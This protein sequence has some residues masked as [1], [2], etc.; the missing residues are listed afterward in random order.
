[1]SEARYSFSVERLKL[2]M[3]DRN[4]PEFAALVGIK[5]GMVSKYLEGESQPSVQSLIKIAAR[6]GT[7][8]DWLVGLSDDPSLRIGDTSDDE[9]LLIMAYKSNNLKKLLD[10]ISQRRK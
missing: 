3:G 1:M 2:L 6:T 7:S 8:I 9:T 4:Q 10:L 5:Q